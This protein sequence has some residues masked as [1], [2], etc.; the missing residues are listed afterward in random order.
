MR[1][2]EKNLHLCV[3]ARLPERVNGREQWKMIVWNKSI[4]RHIRVE[5]R[6]DKVST[7]QEYGDSFLSFRV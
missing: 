1:Y 7:W 5:S 3:G 6:M 4:R 2:I